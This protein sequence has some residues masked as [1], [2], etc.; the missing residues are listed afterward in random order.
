MINFESS[1]III[2]IDMY[3]GFQLDLSQQDSR[4]NDFIREL[5]KYY[6]Q[7]KKLYEEN[8]TTIESKLDYFLLSDNSL[9]GSKMKA[10]WFPQIQSHIFIS[11]SHQDEKLALCLA[12]WLHEHFELKSFIDSAV[13]GYADNLLKQIDNRYCRR[14]DSGLYDYK[15]RNRSTSYI[16]M[17]LSVALAGMIDNT[18]CLFFLNTPHSQS[19]D[20]CI[21]GTTYSPWIYS[22]IAMSR[23]MRQKTKEEYRYPL[24]ES[25]SEGPPIRLPLLM[26]HLTKINSNGLMKWKEEFFSSYE[27]YEDPLDCLYNLPLPRKK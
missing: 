13:W 24:N 21:K 27:C 7:G 9:D 12:G 15:K 18:E 14:E 2:N 1:K 20:A 11:H 3:R 6:Q 10:N 4:N 23:L 8:E 16:H 25:F 17:M 22:E 19:I 5:N 26:D